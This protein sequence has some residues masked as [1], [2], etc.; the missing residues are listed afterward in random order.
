MKSYVRSLGDFIGQELK[1]VTFGKG[2]G[3]KLMVT[4]GI[5]GGEATGIYAATKFIEYLRQHEDELKGQVKVLAV[6]NPGAFRRM[7]R[8]NPYDDLDM[9][10]I[11]PGRADDTPTMVAANIVY[12][13]AQWADYIVDLHCCGIYGSNYTLAIYNESAKDKELASLLDI[14][15]V[16][17][18]G[19]TGGQLFVEA[20]RKFGKA[21][22]IIELTGG[23][24]GG[25][26]DLPAGDMAFNALVK[27]AKQLGMVPG[28][29]ERPNP[30]FCGRLTSMTAPV[31]G[32]FVPIVEKGQMVAKGQV[33]GKLGNEEILAPAKAIIMVAGP[34]RFVFRGQ[35]LVVYACPVE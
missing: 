30:R 5:H 21:A 31:D 14:P 27:L 15:V 8:T 9:N 20:S 35:G 32:L 4:G 19:G 12:E 23:G 22:V 1:F 28:D 18:S 11:F 7:Q 3:P 33:I 13:E 25:T 2:D 6:S 29:V 17:E 10:R 34:A 24:Q 16:I 26:I